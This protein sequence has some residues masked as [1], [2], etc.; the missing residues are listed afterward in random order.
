ML[1]SGTM[2][3]AVLIPALDA[4]DTVG[5]VIASLRAE[6][7]TNVPIFVVDDGS[8]DATARVAENAGAT[9]LRHPKNLGKGAAIR[10]GL[11]AAEKAGC[12]VAVT[13][14][15]DGQHPAREAKR[16]IE[17]CGDPGALVLGMRTLAK[18]GA[19]RA[20]LI[21]NYVANFF[22]SIGNRRLFRDT[23]CGLRRYPVARTLSL[24]TKDQRFGFEA[25]IIFAAQR[26]KVPVVEVPVTVHY[27][28]K[29]RHTTRYRAFEDTVRIVYRITVTIFHPLR[30]VLAAAVVLALVHPAIVRTTRIL[31]P[32]VAIPKDTATRDSKDV[33]LRRVGTDYARHRGKIWE[34]ALSGSPEQ[35]G[36]HQVSLLRD[37]MLANETELWNTFESVVP[38]AVARF[39]IFDIARLRFRNLEQL[40]SEDHRHEIAATALTFDPDPFATRIPSYQRMVYLH[41]LY[42]VSLSFEHSPLIGCSSFAL[43]GSAAE[44]GH[45]LLARTFDFEAGRIFDER[46]AVFFMRES[47]RIPYASVSWPGLVGTVTGMNQAG[48]ALVV[49]GGRAREPRSAGEPLVHTMRDI[50]GRAHTTEEAV[51]LFRQRDAMVSHIVMLA[52]ASGDVAVVERAP[53]EPPSVRHGS[54]KMGVT[55]H[56]EGPW[57]D[58][59]ANVQVKRETSTIA[60]RARLDELLSRLEPGATVEQAIDVLRDKR[61]AGDVELPVG[62]RRA[63]DALIATHGVVMDTTAKVMWVSEGPHLLG[64]FVRFDVARLLATGYDPASEHDVVATAPDPLLAESR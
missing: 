3:S 62:D 64:R 11:R 43:T 22:V 20:N 57:A 36:Q 46:K 19:P 51:L 45:T 31:P 23:Q 53:G 34:V 32:Q 52:D 7:G 49:H 37:E 15:A 5:A 17:E 18:S 56:F 21:G 8:T 27:P 47:G 41:S 33:D 59:P 10:T 58:D 39:L 42:D 6:L 35:I 28:P 1:R 44:R 25:E 9:V 4:V 26:G 61:G 29:S 38:S 24:P 50:L 63:I 13:V 16:L 48:V 40:M 30:W 60:R 54:G 55:N 14:D 12:D 2:R